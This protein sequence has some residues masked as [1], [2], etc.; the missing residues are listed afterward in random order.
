MR[1]NQRI[2]WWLMREPDRLAKRG[3]AISF[4]GARPG[5]SALGAGTPKEAVARGWC[6]LVL[7]PTS[8]GAYEALRRNSRDTVDLARPT[9]LAMAPIERPAAFSAAI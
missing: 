9:A 8:N 4:V 1:R 2:R 6:F 5:L 3:N 7:L